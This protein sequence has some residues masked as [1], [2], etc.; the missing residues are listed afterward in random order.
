VIR[1]PANASPPAVNDQTA[2]LFGDSD[3]EKANG[4]PPIPACSAPNAISDT[5]VAARTG[6]NAISATEKSTH[7][8]EKSS[9]AVQKVA[10]RVQIPPVR[11]AEIMLMSLVQF[12]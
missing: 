1:A 5:P 8:D 7:A 4:H 12:E 11:P 2:L 10:R 6:S 3:P 9:F